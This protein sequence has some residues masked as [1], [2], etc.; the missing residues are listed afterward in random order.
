MDN[1]TKV[2]RTGTIAVAALRGVS[3][4][5]DAGEYVSII[6]PSGSGKSTL[7]HILGCLDVPTSGQYWLGGEDVGH[8]DEIDLAE[9]RNR[10]I[11]FVFQQFN[12]LASLSAWRNVE[13]PLDLRRYGPERTAGNA[14]SRR[15]NGW[16][17]VTGSITGPVSCPAV[18][19]SGWQ[20]PGRWS[21]TRP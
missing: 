9:V 5:I 10:Q 19:S 8:M 12:L 13:L 16:V 11:G 7:M 15:S 18:S 2:Y 3:F 6:G 20:W 21:A 17:W 14:A 1:V 4:A